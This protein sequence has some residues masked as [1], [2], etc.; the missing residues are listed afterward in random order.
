[1]SRDPAP[2]SFPELLQPNQKVFM[3]LLRPR[4]A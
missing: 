4:H 2:I 1:M 3:F